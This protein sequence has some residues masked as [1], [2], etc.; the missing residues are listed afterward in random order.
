MGRF[1]LTFRPLARTPK[2]WLSSLVMEGDPISRLRKLQETL[3]T[4]LEEIRVAQRRREERWQQ[5]D[6]QRRQRW[7]DLALTRKA[8]FT[9][10]TV[11]ALFVAFWGV[12]TILLFSRGEEQWW[13]PAAFMAVCFLGILG[14][15]K[16]LEIMHR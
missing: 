4:E 3:E 5:E 9:V 10:N 16:F 15:N 1:D 8:V 13:V 7:E 12:I 11:F 6:E 2:T 14:N